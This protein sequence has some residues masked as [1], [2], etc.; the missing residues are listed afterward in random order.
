MLSLVANVQQSAAAPSFAVDPGAV[1]LTR[2]Y[3]ILL[4]GP[5]IS[6]AGF[7]A[8]A[9][10]SSP[11]PLQPVCLYFN[12]DGF[13][14]L[15]QALLSSLGA[16]LVPAQAIS[17]QSIYRASLSTSIA[18]SSVGLAVVVVRSRF[19]SSVSAPTFA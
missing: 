3:F 17:G 2:V 10:A 19:F 16:V 5:N 15:S 13:A 7:S 4:P 18:A 6:S 8:Q 9:I 12:L 14:D 1:G 11:T